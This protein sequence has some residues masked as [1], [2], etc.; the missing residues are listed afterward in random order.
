MG[1]HRMF[2]KPQTAAERM[3]RYRRRQKASQPKPAT[4][5]E[6]LARMTKKEQAMF[7]DC[8]VRYLQHLR[9]VFENTMIKWD[10]DVMNGKHGK[11]GANFL[12]EVCVNAPFEDI[13]QRINDTI[14]TEG[15]AAGRALWYALRRDESPSP[16]KKR[17]EV[18]AALAR[19]IRE[20]RN[21]I[22]AR[23]IADYIDD[24]FS[25]VQAVAKALDRLRASG[26]YDRIISGPIVRLQNK[27]G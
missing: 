20:K 7:C 9:T 3:R 17:A 21:D 10:A 27:P 11:V 19:F 6:A 23:A 8:S 14:K 13:Q 26:E 18:A 16:I 4:A 1:R 22:S 2:D 15:A 5:T 12:A 24:P 25:S